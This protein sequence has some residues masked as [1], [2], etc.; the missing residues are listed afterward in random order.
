MDELRA[1]IVENSKNLITTLVIIG[2]SILI[3]LILSFVFN[4]L[5]K[6][7]KNKRTITITKLLRSIIRYTITII[8]IV[9]LIGVWEIVDIMPIITGVGVLGLVI[10]LGAQSLIKDLIAGISIVFDNYYEIDDIVEIKGFKGKVLEVGLKSTR[11]QNWKGEVK[12]FSNGDIIDVINF[13]KNPSVGVVDVDVAYQEDIDRVLKL[14]DEDL[15]NIKETF[16]Q[17]IEGPNIIGLVDIGNTVTIRITVKTVSEEHYAVERGIRK[18]LKELFEKNK[19]KM[20]FT[21]TIIYDGET[22]NEL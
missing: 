15:A 4:R 11:L 2:L 12:I 7:Q 5:I 18:Y 14:I 6:R 9:V 10:G 22:S 8:V 1:F 13:S 3:F 17:I 16:P 21:K 19:I 20:P